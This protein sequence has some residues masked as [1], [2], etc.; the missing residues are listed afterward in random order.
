MIGVID[1][2]HWGSGQPLMTSSINKN[3]NCCYLR[4]KH[5]KLMKWWKD[6]N[7]LS[8]TVEHFIC[9]RLTFELGFRI[10]LHKLRGKRIFGP[11][12]FRMTTHAAITRTNVINVQTN[13][14]VIL[15][16]IYYFASILTKFLKITI[17]RLIYYVILFRYNLS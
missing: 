10:K 14:L 2:G 5:L 11:L 16:R 13:F 6:F 17:W 4:T 3:P 7:L 8:V 12:R 1:W 9:V 15:G